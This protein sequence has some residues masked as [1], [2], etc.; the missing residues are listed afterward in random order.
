M[1][2]TSLYDLEPGAT[3]AERYRIVGPHRQTGL[4]AA[5]EAI[6]E[7]ETGES[8][9]CEV[10]LYAHSFFESREQALQFAASWTPWMRVEKN[11]VLHVREVASLSPTSFLLVTDFPPG[12]TLRDDLAERKRLEASEVV[13]I[14]RQLLSGLV[15]VHGHGLVHGDLKPATIYV[16]RSE[17]V[18]TI[19]VDGGVTPGLWSAKQLGE[20]TALIGT[21][22]YA[23]IEQFGGDSPNIQSDI[24][25]VATVL[26]EALTGVLPWGGKSFLE[27]FQAK[28]DKTP[29]SMR[30]RAPDVDVEP[31]LEQA[32]VTGLLADKSQ[33]YA[34]SKEFLDRLDALAV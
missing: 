33:R 31:Q 12:K 32:I 7:A 9:R 34:T 10:S 2:S 4:A 13:E 16:D 3:L 14:G 5:F 20:K 1:E 28:L 27:V 11:A 8:Q 30:R 21:P 6:D 15:G 22:F 25:N 29:P 23:P 26:F 24:Y 19:M 17:S 18:R